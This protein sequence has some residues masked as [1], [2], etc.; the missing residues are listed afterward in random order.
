MAGVPDVDAAGGVSSYLDT[1]TERISDYPTHVR[2]HPPG[3]VVGLWA[4]DQ[5]GL[6]PVEVNLALVLLGWAAAV[7][8]GLVAAR[9]VAGE[10]AARRMAPLLALAPGAIWAGTS[11]DAFFAGVTGAAVA[12]LVLATGR[13]G[14]RA[15]VTA[16]A[17]GVLVGVSLLLSYATGP[18]LAVP[19]TVALVRRRLRPLVVG[20]AAALAVL[21]VAGLA[22]F[23]WPAG[24][25]ATREEYH[26]GLSQLRPLRY[27]VVGNLAAV[28][29]AVGPALGG[30]VANLVRRLRPG[31]LVVGALVGVAAADLS[32]LSKGE[33]ERIWLVFV[34]WLAGAAAFL[35]GRPDRVRAG[36]GRAAGG[37][38]HR[39][40]GRPEDTLVTASASA[41]P[42][43]RGPSAHGAPPGDPYAS[44]MGVSWDPRTTRA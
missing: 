8:A 15:D 31:A 43:P 30:G 34:P 41:P 5:I 19:V 16:A 32:G 13:E 11:P 33:T 39:V 40:P 6:D 18:V 27:F 37:G 4:A 44:V 38:G 14:R 12:A 17:G 36:L 10:P 2:G 23:W 26:D 29:V 20:A 35:P 42:G 9:D 7:A 1:F 25:L 3:L 28:A 22:G 24:L 21:L